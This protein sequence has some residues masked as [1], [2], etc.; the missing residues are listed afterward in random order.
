MN[1]YN[2]DCA[3]PTDAETMMWYT[4]KMSTSGEMLTNNIHSHEITNVLTLKDVSFRDCYILHRSLEF[5]GEQEEG[6]PT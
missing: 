1:V 2:N 6:A 3:V 5:Q 4:A